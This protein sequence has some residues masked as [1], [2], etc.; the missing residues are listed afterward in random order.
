VE[1]RTSPMLVLRRSGPE[2]VLLPGMVG[3]LEPRTK[4]GISQL[5]ARFLNHPPRLRPRQQIGRPTR[6]RVQQIVRCSPKGNVVISST[7]PPAAPLVTLRAKPY[8]HPLDPE[9]AVF[10]PPHRYAEGLDS[11]WPCSFRPAT[12]LTR[13][14]DASLLP[15]P[16]ILMDSSGGAAVYVDGPGIAGIWLPCHW[17]PPRSRVRDD[18]RGR[19]PASKAQEEKSFCN[20]PRNQANHGSG[21]LAL[22]RESWDDSAHESAIRI[23]G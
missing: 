5:P 19:R 16:S 14:S 15:P 22:Q 6:H 23:P 18:F 13:G 11:G 3:S 4:K 20:R 7:Q 12:T 8:Q 2:P 1:K 21:L 10:S 17:R 9:A